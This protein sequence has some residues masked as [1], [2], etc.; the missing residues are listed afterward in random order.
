MKNTLSVM[1]S[2]GENGDDLNFS[3]WDSMP[4]LVCATTV[5]SHTPV[6]SL[7]LFESQ[8]QTLR[9]WQKG[10]SPWCLPPDPLLLST[11]R[12]LS[13]HTELSARVPSATRN[14]TQGWQHSAPYEE[15]SIT[16]KR[17]CVYLLMLASQ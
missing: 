11:L 6:E 1:G 13:A 12:D 10:P 4:C 2:T 7:P 16:S 5:T 9:T 14:E 3:L 8:C 15:I 17:L